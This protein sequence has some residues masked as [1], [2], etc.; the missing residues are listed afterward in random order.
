MEI[1]ASVGSLVIVY[2]IVAAIQLTGCFKEHKTLIFM[3]KPLLMPLLIAVYVLAAGQNVSWLIVVALCFDTIGDIL[4]MLRDTGGIKYLL[5]GM[6]AF[7]IG[8]LCYIYWFFSIAESF[9][10]QP[11]WILGVIGTIFLIVWFWRTMLRSGHRYAVFLS[12][13]SICI[14]AMIIGALYSWGSGPL[15]G[16]LS[17]VAGTL[18]FC[19]SDFFI[20]METIGRRIGDRG[21]VM[22]TYMLAQFLLVI[23]FI[24]L[25]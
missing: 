17:C 4:L 6:I 24:V 19:L 2:L 21:S 9:S 3:S 1:D 14:A 15:V 25:G 20:A 13:Y 12:S 22:L 23:G 16:T 8:H 7:M 5:S 11:A 10:V 18:L